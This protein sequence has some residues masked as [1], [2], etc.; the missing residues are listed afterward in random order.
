MARLRI[1]SYRHYLG[2][3]D[4]AARLRICHGAKAA[5]AAESAP[6]DRELAGL[7]ARDIIGDGASLSTSDDAITAA[8]T[9]PARVRKKLWALD[10]D[11]E[12]AV[13]TPR[14]A[15]AFQAYGRSVAAF[16]RGAG[17]PL[18][19]TFETRLVAGA[20]GNNGVDDLALHPANAVVLIN[21]GESDV[22]IATHGELADAHTEVSLRI[23][24]DEGCLLSPKARPYVVIVP[25][26][27][28][29]GLLLELA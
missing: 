19:E 26:E 1:A 11:D 15:A 18:A 3:W 8:L 20:P 22:L 5:R 25:A 12:A 2:T 29:F 23:P 14:D 27:A 13:M 10:W 24:P 9:V 28:E 7:G 21:V 4:P 16:L 17:V 6:D